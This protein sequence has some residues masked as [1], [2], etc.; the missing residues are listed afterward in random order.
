MMTPARSR[1]WPD[2]ADAIA[3]MIAGLILMPGSDS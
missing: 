3:T 1:R 2:G